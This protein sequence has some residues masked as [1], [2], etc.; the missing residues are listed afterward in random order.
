MDFL[1]D[2]SADEPS[3]LKFDFLDEHILCVEVKL[4]KIV[5]WKM[6][7]DETIN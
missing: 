4:S 3:S 7:F 2:E 5:R 1:V 6:C